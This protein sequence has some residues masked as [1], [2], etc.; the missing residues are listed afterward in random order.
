MVRITAPHTEA[1][2]A[3]ILVQFLVATGNAMGRSAGFKAEAT[4]HGTNLYALIVGRT[5]KGRKG[6]SWGQARWPVELAAGEE[7]AGRIKSGISSGEGLIFAVR[8]Q[9][10]STRKATKEEKKNGEAD[11][12]G[13]ITEITDAG[14]ED[15]RLLAYESEYA[16]VL[17]VMRRD[18]SITNTV[19]RQGWETGKLETMTRNNPM[20]ATDAHVSIVGHISKRSCV[21]S[22]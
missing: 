1:D 19:I 20:R 9:V 11:L 21:G 14:E 5:S 4:F 7:W 15:K 16:A 12:E 10:E 17:R 2:P 8:D 22:F 13:S 18:G 3:A 6:S